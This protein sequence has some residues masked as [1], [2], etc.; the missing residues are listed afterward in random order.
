MFRTIRRPSPAMLVATAALVA[1]GTGT[2]AAAGLITGADIK[3]GSV[4]SADIGNS[5]LKGLDVK[6]GSLTG[7]DLKKA[8]ISADR[9]TAAAK[10]S[11][12]GD[13]GDKGDPGAPGLQG[14][15]GLQGEKGEKGDRGPSEVFRAFTGNPGAMADAKTAVDTREFPVGSYL[16]TASV[17]VVADGAG[18]GAECDLVRNG[19][20]LGRSTLEAAGA[21]RQR[22]MVQGTTTITSAIAA[23]N[24]VSF[25]CADGGD[26]VT[27]GNL[28]I[29]ALQVG[30][31]S[32][33][34]EP[35][36]L[37]G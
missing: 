14:A 36:G 12:K 8:S 29:T 23:Q 33:A 28:A 6:N 7:A 13:K 30:Q 10:A 11:L 34:P 15:Q 31:V 22:L 32:E 4:K 3:N 18:D 20:V 35:L 25:S 24:D 16:L 19:T 27:M 17:D 5:S 21:G 1:G 2:A 37:G 9:L 26:G